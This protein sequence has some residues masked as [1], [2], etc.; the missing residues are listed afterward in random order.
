M[1]AITRFGALCIAAAVTMT[2]AAP[3]LAENDKINV[4]LGDVSLNKVAFIVAAENGLYDKYGLDVHQFITSQ[5][6]NRIKKSGIVV[7]DDYIG[8]SKERDEAQIAV[9]GGSPLIASMTL[10][11]NATDRVIVATTDSTARFHIIARPEIESIDDLKGKRLGYSSFGS[12]S[13]LMARALLQKKG[14]S[15][16]DDISL[17]EEGMDYSALSAGKVDAFIGSSIYYSMASAKGMKDLI[18]LG[19]YDI[20]IAGSGINVERAYLEG[21]RDVVERFLKA[22][23][24]SYALM[25]KDRA[26]FDAALVKWYGINAQDQQDTMYEQVL[27][28]PEKPYPAVEGIRLV[29]AIYHQRELKRYP[30]DHFYDASFI[31]DLDKSGFIARAYAD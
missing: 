4:S 15:E 2:L 17:M 18:D 10:E 19:E 12:V 9:G 5:A 22:M 21:H 26:A 29:K 1:T 16:E 11:A 3:A 13:H 14:W 25:R 23:V 27:E 24:E 8:T 6:A 7:P 30:A 31:E 28:V 20:P